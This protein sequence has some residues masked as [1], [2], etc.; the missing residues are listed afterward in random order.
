MGG[1]AKGRAILEE[2]QYLMEGN[3]QERKAINEGHT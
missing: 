3:T 1:Q 2:G